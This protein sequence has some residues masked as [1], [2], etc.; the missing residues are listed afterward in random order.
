M[1][2]LKDRH[3]FSSIG[4]G[5][6]D[7]TL[8]TLNLLRPT[9]LFWQATCIW[10]R[11][12]VGVLFLNL[13]WLLLQLTIVLGPPA[14]AVLYTISQR[15]VNDEPWDFQDIWRLLKQMFWPAWKWALP[16]GLLLVVLVTNFYAY[17]QFQ[18][19]GW[20]ALRLMWGLLLIGWFGANL[21]Y[22]PFWCA[23]ADRSLKTTY[24]NVGR[25]FLAH[26]GIVIMVMV[27]SAIILTLS[28]SLVFLLAAGVMGWIALLGV[29]TV[30]QALAAQNNNRIEE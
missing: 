22:W 20:I 18:G 13:V 27:V 8:P 28:L 6:G 10:W 19:H 7:L 2:V 3:F 17:Q 26:P 14:T 30:Q 11:E 16:N 23:Q 24:A 21:F 25:L 12:W 4:G 1:Q 29:L 15:M 5:H 9:H